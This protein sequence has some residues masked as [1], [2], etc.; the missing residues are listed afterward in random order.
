[1][2]LQQARADF[3]AQLLDAGLLVAAGPGGLYGRSGT[4]EDIVDAVDRL[5]VFAGADQHAKRFRFP[6]VFLREEFDKTD[7]I[8][9]FPNLTG[10]VS[11][12]TGDDKAHAELLA[13]RAAGQDWERLLA[14][15]GVMLVSAACHPAYSMMRGQ[16]PAGGVVLDVCGY[17][18]R[19]E[20]AVDPAR[21]QA[22][23]QHEYVYIGDPR[24][25]VAHRDTWVSRASEVLRSIGLDVT[26]E[27]ANDPFFGRAGRMLASNQREEALKFELVVHFYGGRS[28][29]DTGTAVASANC[30]LDHFGTAFEITSAD[31][32]VAHSACVGF[33]MERIAL[34]LLRTHGLD[35]QCWPEDVRQRLWR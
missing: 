29:G 3:R 14:P 13:T 32:R 6:P 35:P 25:A 19:H 2:D 5:I 34:A 26:S 31:G 33:G 30:H 10:S 11:T 17:C 7:Y 16:V 21:M 9:S 4:F 22:F 24:G 27:V 12:F 15:A 28:Q 1:M 23:R 20:P 18:F 8:S